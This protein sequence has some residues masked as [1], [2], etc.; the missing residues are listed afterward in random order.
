[1]G[2]GA[3]RQIIKCEGGAQL[4]AHLQQ[5]PAAQAPRRGGAA[6]QTWSNATQNALDSAAARNSLVCTQSP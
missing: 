1:V 3:G 5:Q 2:V 4:G 6:G